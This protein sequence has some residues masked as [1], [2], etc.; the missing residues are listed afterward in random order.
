MI[1]KLRVELIVLNYSSTSLYST[2]W[3]KDECTYMNSPNKTKQII[4]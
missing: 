3:V 4:L 1:Y 2:E